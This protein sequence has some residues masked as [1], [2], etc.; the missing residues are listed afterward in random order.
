MIMK[1]TFVM[2]GVQC[3]LGILPTC[4][5]TNSNV[6]SFLNLLIISV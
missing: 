6:I 5:A 2:G 1:A 3:R 4:T